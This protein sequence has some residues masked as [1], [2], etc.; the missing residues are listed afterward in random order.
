M[1]LGVPSISNVHLVKDRGNSL[2]REGNFVLAAR[3][4]TQALKLVRFLG[5]PPI[6]DQPVA[7]SLCLSLVLNLAGCQ[8]KLSQFNRVCCYCTFVLSFDPSNV[9]A[10]Y[11]R[12]LAFKH[13]NFLNKAL[14]DFEHVVKL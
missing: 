4:Y 7:T 5:L 12:G 13:L 9:K 8:L 10:L 1:E 6:H 2:F 14:D 3:H 11:R